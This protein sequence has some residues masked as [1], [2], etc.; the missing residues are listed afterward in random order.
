MIIKLRLAIA[1]NEIEL[2]NDKFAK[3]TVFIKH[4]DDEITH[5]VSQDDKGNTNWLAISIPEKEA[6]RQINFQNGF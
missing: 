3:G 2:G 5:A 4:A 6:F 1:V